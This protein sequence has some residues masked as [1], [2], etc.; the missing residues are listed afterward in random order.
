MDHTG[1]SYRCIALST[2]MLSPNSRGSNRLSI[3]DHMHV[4]S[5]P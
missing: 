5:T 3:P 2:R 1:G 4:S